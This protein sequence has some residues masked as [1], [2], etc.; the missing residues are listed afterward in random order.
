M[1]VVQFPQ[2]ENCMGMFYMAL[3]GLNNLHIIA[4]KRMEIFDQ[5]NVSMYIWACVPLSVWVCAYEM[6]MWVCVF[7]SLTQPDILSNYEY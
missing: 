1:T 7:D 6:G 3:F 4:V 5:N 2:Q